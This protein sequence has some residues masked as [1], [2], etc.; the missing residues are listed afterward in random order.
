VRILGLDLGT[1]RIGVAVSD[2]LLFTAQGM[3]T[4]YRK[5]L[6]SDLNKLKSVI[7]QNNI[8]EIVVGLPLNMNGT[9]GPKADE[10]VRFVESLSKVT[11]VPI[12]TQDERLTTVQANRALLE[13]DMSR[14]KRKMLADKLAAQF[15]LQAYLDSRKKG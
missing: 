9:H 1:K 6:P 8:E 11:S 4:I 15:I 5:D 13:A 10:V 2:E 3:E 14:S 7:S 12:R